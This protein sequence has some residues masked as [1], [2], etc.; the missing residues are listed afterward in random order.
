LFIVN[1][2]LEPKD[3]GIERPK[4][5]DD[6]EERLKKAREVPRKKIELN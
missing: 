2:Q 1:R 5:T 4:E 6:V 3:F